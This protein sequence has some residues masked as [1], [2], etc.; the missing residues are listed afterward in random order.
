MTAHHEMTG[1]T[2][3]DDDRFLPARAVWERYN[4][5][6]MSIWRW[7]RDADMAF[8]QPVLFGRLR[9]WKLSELLMWEASRPRAGA[10]LKNLQGRVAQAEQIA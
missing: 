9:Y 3:G 4:V 5:T 7:L 1:R 6:S 8:P 2:H 10:Q